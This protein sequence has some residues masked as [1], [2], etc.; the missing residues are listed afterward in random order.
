MMPNG[1]QNN[2]SHVRNEILEQ[3]FSMFKYTCAQAVES[4]SQEPEPQQ[5]LSGTNSSLFYPIAMQPLMTTPHFSESRDFVCC[6]L[7]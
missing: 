4:R 3:K 5:G 6:I 7:Y 2:L 1:D